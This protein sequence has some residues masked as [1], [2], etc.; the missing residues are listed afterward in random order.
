MFVLGAM[1]LLMNVLLVQQNKKLQVLAT[2]PDRALEIKLGTALPPLEGL[3]SNGNKHSFNYGQDRRK[4]VLLVLSP[5][6]HAC[7]ENMPNWAAIING[8]DR[9]SFR[10]AAVSLQS[11]GSEEYI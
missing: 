2:R 10:L 1:L 6:C 9:R 11:N 7:E 5:R 8:F 4:T 3:D